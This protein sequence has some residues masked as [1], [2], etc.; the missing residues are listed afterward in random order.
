MFVKCHDNIICGSFIKTTIRTLSKLQ[1]H[2]V[3]NNIKSTSN[4]ARDAQNKNI[5]LKS[6]FFKGR[7]E[8]I[9]TT[10][11]FCFQVLENVKIVS[12]QQKMLS[13]RLSETTFLAHLTHFRKRSSFSTEWILANVILVVVSL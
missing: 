9:T 11:C 2:D 1:D 4:G 6:S 13:Y 5:Q 7:L 12:K 10:L 3:L 8:N